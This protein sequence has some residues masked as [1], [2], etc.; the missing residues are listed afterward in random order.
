MTIELKIDDSEWLKAEALL[1]RVDRELR[2]EAVEESLEKASKIVEEEAKRQAPPPG[3]PG[4]K[5]RKKPLRD[6]IS[7]KIE[8]YQSGNIVSIVGPQYPAGAHAHLVH[9]G[10]EIWVPK[11]PFTEGADTERTGQRTQPDKFLER[12][13]DNTQAAQAQAIVSTLT[14]RASSIQ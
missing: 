9:E 4:D 14:K 13:A 8:K 2:Q 1:Q 10:H 3:Y 6:T 7:H 12:A 11:P 5:P